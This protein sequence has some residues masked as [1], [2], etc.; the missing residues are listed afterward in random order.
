MGKVDQ[1]HYAECERDPNRHEEQD[2][3]ELHAIEGL[4]DQ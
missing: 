2:H 3:S 4:L 1:V